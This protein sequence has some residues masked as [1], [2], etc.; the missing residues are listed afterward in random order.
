MLVGQQCGGHQYGALPAVLRRDK[1]SPHRH[2]GFT[3]TDIATNQPIHHS[4]RTHV[5]PHCRNG[6][7]LIRRL[8]EGEA[9]AERVPF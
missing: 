3:E 8:F 5:V 1:R 9:L 2:L 4:W 7:R 6:R